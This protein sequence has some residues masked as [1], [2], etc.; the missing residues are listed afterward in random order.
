MTRYDALYSHAHESWRIASLICHTELK[1]T[2]N[3][4]NTT[5]MLRRNGPVIKWVESVLRPEGSLWWER[6]VEEV[7]VE[8]WV[9][10]I[11]SYGRCYVVD[12][13]TQVPGYTPLTQRPWK[14]KLDQKSSAQS[15]FRL[16]IIVRFVH[17][18]IYREIFSKE[19]H[20]AECTLRAST[21]RCQSC[22]FLSLGHVRLPTSLSATNSQRTNANSLNA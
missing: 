7:V 6:F 21:G 4:E 11:R 9:K 14:T 13:K 1:K 20:T 10:E 12:H 5:E 16:Y 2:K 19:R 18:F 17:W 22:C 15:H 8:P 3:E